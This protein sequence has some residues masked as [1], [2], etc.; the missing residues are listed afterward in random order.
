MK[1]KFIFPLLAVLCAGCLMWSAGLSRPA[2]LDNDGNLSI[3]VDDSRV[4]MADFPPANQ[5]EEEDPFARFTQEQRDFMDEILALVNQARAEAGLSALELNPALC[6]A[7]QV[8]A[9][10]CVSTFS[11]TRPNGSSYKTAIAEMGI[12]A[13][14]VGENVATGYKDAQQVVNAWLKSEGHRANIL[15][16]NYT[17]IGI[18]SEKNTGN[19]YRGY[20]WSQLFIQ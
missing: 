17:K 16:E 20:A 7:A 4:P 2:L 5:G 12:T 10:E 19:R 13:D 11:H 3:E 6:G 1:Q 18:G 15:N 14:Y 9:K 8:R